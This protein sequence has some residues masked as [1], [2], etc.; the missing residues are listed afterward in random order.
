MFAGVVAEAYI[1]GRT[2]RRGISWERAWGWGKGADKGPDHN[3]TL[4]ELAIARP[5][6]K[7]R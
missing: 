3:Q 2:R 6:I 4:L 7:D 5:A 1:L